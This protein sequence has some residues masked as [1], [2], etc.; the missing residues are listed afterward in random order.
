MIKRIICQAKNNGGS[1]VELSFR[2]DEMTFYVT[3][4]GYFVAGYGKA[5]TIEEA[6]KIFLRCCDAMITEENATKWRKD[7]FTND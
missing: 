4:D 2:M 6:S 5:D 7:R 1:L 3:V